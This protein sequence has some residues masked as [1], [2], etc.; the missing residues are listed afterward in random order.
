MLGK[1]FV[2]NE[3][4]KFSEVFRD[5]DHK[6]PMIFVLS[7]G[8]DPLQS[9]QRFASEASRKLVAISLGQGSLP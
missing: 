6:T 4:A 1:V 7:P 2:A 3:A 8:S 9:L 5:C